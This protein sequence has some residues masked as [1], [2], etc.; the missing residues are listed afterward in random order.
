MK[1]LTVAAL[2]CLM[3]AV[4]ILGAQEK[5]SLIFNLGLV[6]GRDEHM[7]FPP[8]K[9]DLGIELLREA[10]YKLFY[11]DEV[12]RAGLLRSGL[13]VLTIETRHWFEQSGEHRFLLEIKSDRQLEQ[14]PFSIQV[15][16]DSEEALSG[17]AEGDR[18]I[19]PKEYSLSLFLDKK[20]LAAHAK[21]VTLSI[22]SDFDIPIMPRNYD[23]N[24]PNSHR[25]PLANTFSI[26]D[27]VGLAYYLARQAL[28]PDK[29][30]TPA[31]SLR[32]QKQ[33]TVTY[34]HTHLQGGER[35]VS[36]LLTFKTQDEDNM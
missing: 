28:S 33:M 22:P 9:L 12:V 10:N 18:V 15:D 13:N 17:T 6:A 35:R 30:K 3:A 14:T 2:L 32:I 19:Q 27:A 24:D 25:D 16:L 29:G 26:L 34:V 31:M 21:P 8:G 5:T 11:E 20:L 7:S 36:A 23:P 1:R 4:W